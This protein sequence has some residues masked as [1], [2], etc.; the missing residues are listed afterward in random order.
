MTTTRVWIRYEPQLYCD[1]FTS[2]LQGED[3]VQ[4]VDY[5]EVVDPCKSIIQTELIDVIVI[6]LDDQD[7]PMLELLPLPTPNVKLI[8]FSPRGDRGF[9]RYPGQEQWEEVTPYGLSNLMAEFS[10]KT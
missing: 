10:E 6:S 3:C 8:A 1:L 5:S 4:V 2:I 9:R 7:R